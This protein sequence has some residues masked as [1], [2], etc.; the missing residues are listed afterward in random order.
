MNQPVLFSGIQ[1]SGV[2]NIGNYLGA[3]K[4]WLGLQADHD[5]LFSIVDLH[6]ITVCQAPDILRQ[7]CLD[8]FAIYLACG[9]DPDKSTVFIQSHVPQHSQL[10]WILNCYT[11]MGELNRMTQF[12]DKSQQHASNINVGL[13]DYPV[14]MAADILLYGT[15]QVPVGD[16]QKQHLELARDIALRFNHHYGDILT[17]PEVF[18]PPVGAR[19]MSL[20]DPTKKM[21]KS[22]PNEGSRVNLLDPP[23]LII[24]KIK[25]SVTDSGTE[26]K[27]DPTKPGINNLLHLY[28]AVSDLSIN[29]IEVAYDGKGY[30]HLKADTADRIVALLEPI[31]K[32]Y[33]ELRQ[34]DD[35]LLNLLHEHAERARNRADAILSKVH[36]AIGLVSV[37]GQHA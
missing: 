12:K 33:E 31:Q 13:F 32:Q 9:I 25:R 35:H 23:K 30:G 29:E 14:L 1:P 11:Q 8:T 26:I 22:D 18:I 36:E 17:V 37:R 10:A 16:D 24:K 6:A 20:Q 4:N 15:Q 3:I 28:S 27:A 2:L 5:C 21:S 19:I 7:R 34:H